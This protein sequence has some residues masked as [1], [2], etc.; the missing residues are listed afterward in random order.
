MIVSRSRTMHPQPPPPL[1]LG[2]TVLEESVDLDTLGVAFDGKMTFVKDLRH[3]SIA[4]PLRFGILRMFCITFHDQWLLNRLSG[5]CLAG[6]AV[7]SCDVV[8]GCRYT[9]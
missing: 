2:G 8:L 3:A 6:F 1:T 4:A 5:F 9:P 7:Q